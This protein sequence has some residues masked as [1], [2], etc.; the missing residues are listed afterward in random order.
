MTQAESLND[1]LA[2]WAQTHPTTA[3]DEDRQVREAFVAKFPLEHLRDL[4]LEQYAIGRGDAENLCYW[5][6]WKTGMLGSIRGGT[7]KKFGVYW[8]QAQAAYWFNPR[9]ATPDDGEDSHSGC[10]SRGRH[11]LKE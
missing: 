10:H 11:F 5:L 9:F 6:E 1:R 8:S 3:S 7:S 4:T 2:R